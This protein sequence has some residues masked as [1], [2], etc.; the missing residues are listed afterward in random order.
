MPDLKLSEIWIYPIKSLGG[1]RLSSARVMPKGLQYDRRW[2]L[3]DHDGRY[4]TQRIH[5]EMALFK[6]SFSQENFI[7]R[8]GEDLIHL[9]VNPPISKNSL[10]ATIWDDVVEVYE[11]LGEYSQWFSE[12]LGINCRLVYF[13]EIELRLVDENYRLEDDQVSLADAYPFLIIGQASLDDLNKRLKNPLRMDRFRPNFV[14]TG[15][16]PF[17]EDRFSNFTIGENKFVGVKPCSRCTLTTVNQETAEKGVEPVATLATYRKENNKIYFGQN[18]LAK[19]FN[20]VYEGDK[21]EK[22]A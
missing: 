18:L 1:I 5:S 16:E 6:L 15:G 2:M 4:I 8:F 17:E 20:E 12:R 22:I 9:P 19:D 11:V 13:P 3:I 7:I 14:F 10:S 21:I